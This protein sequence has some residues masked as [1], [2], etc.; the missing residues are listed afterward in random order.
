[1]SSSQICFA[2][3]P[4]KA[5]P[6]HYQCNTA[7]KSEHVVSLSLS[8]SLSVSL[9]LSLT[10]TRTHTHTR[11]RHHQCNTACKAEQVV[12]PHPPPQADTHA[13]TQ[14]RT[15]T[16]WFHVREQELQILNTK[17]QL[18]TQCNS[19]SITMSQLPPPHSSFSRHLTSFSFY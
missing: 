14:A 3:G 6:R 2:L 9:C 5:R 4:Y 17:T 11:T 18:T 15:H 13:R 1:M 19:G 12:S 8:F 16:K 7:C 10:H